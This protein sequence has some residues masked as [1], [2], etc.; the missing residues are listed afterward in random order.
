[1]Q[2]VVC[3]RGKRYPIACCFAGSTMRM[4]V[5]FKSVKLLLD[6]REIYYT[7]QRKILHH[8]SKVLPVY[9]YNN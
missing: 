7:H 3:G 8:R 4:I 9:T 1:M 5:D 2:N 6:I